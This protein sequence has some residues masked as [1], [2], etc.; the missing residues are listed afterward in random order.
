M[1]LLQRLKYWC[2]SVIFSLF[3][4]EKIKKSS[5]YPVSSI[6]GKKNYKRYYRIDENGS[7]LERI[8]LNISDMNIREEIIFMHFMKN[9]QKI[10]IKKKFGFSVI[11]RDQPWD[12]KIETSKN[13]KFNLEITSI[14]DNEVLFRNVK[15]EERFNDLIKEKNVPL[16]ELMKINSYFPDEEI[17]K[18]IEEYIE[19]KTPK[20]HLVDNPYFGTEFPLFISNIPENE[21]SLSMILKDTIDKKNKKNH[22][23]KDDTILVIDNRT[24][25]FEREDFHK[26]SRELKDYL[27]LCPFKEIWFYTGYFSNLDGSDSEFS[28]IPAK[29][30]LKR[31]KL[32]AKFIESQSIGDG[33]IYL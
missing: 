17:S 20:K 10:F 14:A 8:F 28:F 3:K 1:N 25:V 13:N 18:Q 29:I 19:K 4:K 24:L 6:D 31:K 7:I 33:M 5:F 30:S 21:S 15:S 11:S 2:N 12:F 27:E 16:R 22:H 9:E 26:A 23:D 32:L